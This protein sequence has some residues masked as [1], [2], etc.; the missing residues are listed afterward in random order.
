MAH[1]RPPVRCSLADGLDALTAQWCRK[2][3]LWWRHQMEIFFALLTIYAENSPV[4]AQRPVTRSF[5]VF[6]DLRPN[7]RLN[8]RSWGWWFEMPLPP[9]WRHCNDISSSY[10]VDGL[11]SIIKMSV[12]WAS[13]T[14]TTRLFSASFQQWKHHSSAL[15]VTVEWNRQWPMD[16]PHEEPIMW[17]VCPCH[18]VIMMEDRI[19]LPIQCETSNQ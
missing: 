18:N 6:F 8:K 9:L 16:S 14:T 13:E 3:L 12:I 7:K 17:K 10:C 5:D 2:C 19:D 11:A 1:C 4:T 15:L